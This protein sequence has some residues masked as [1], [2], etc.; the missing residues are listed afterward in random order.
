MQILK[1]LFLYIAFGLKEECCAFGE[2]REQVDFE[3]SMGKQGLK[4]MAWLE[5]SLRNQPSSQNF[6]NY[7]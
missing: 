4:I 7:L 2:V 3:H 1:I 6:D 5:M